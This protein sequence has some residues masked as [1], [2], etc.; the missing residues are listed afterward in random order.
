MIGIVRFT[1]IRHEINHGI[2][3]GNDVASGLVHVAWDAFGDLLSRLEHEG[4]VGAFVRN[5]LSARRSW[6]RI[7][8]AECTGA[9]T[10]MLPITTAVVWGSASL[11]AMQS[12]MIEKGNTQASAV[13]A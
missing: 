13:Y 7:D 8:D 10:E 9:T 6:V 1:N 3:I 4:R 11:A 5:S 12:T 2:V